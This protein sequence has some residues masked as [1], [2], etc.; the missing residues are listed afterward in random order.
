MTARS[1]K[2]RRN[3]SGAH[4][5]FW[6]PVC[7]PRYPV[8]ATRYR[9]WPLLLEQHFL[10]TDARRR[11]PEVPVRLR[12][13]HAAARRA[14]KEALLDE[15]RLVHFLERARILA[16]RCADRGHADWT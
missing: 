11:V 7:Q 14:L 2:A 6:G 13:R 4:E 1:R 12:R 15:E 5:A 8:F 10:R 16:D 9:D 3:Q